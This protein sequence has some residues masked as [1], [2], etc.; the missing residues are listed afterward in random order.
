MSIRTYTQPGAFGPEAIAAMSQAFDAACK[1]VNHTGQP[2]EAVR[3]VLAQRI[4]EAATAGER[5]ADRLRAAA[6]AGLTDDPDLATPST[7]H[8]T[9]PSPP[10][11]WWDIYPA[12]TTGAAIRYGEVE[13]ADERE[14]VEKAAEKFQQP[15]EKLIAVRRPT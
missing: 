2:S 7:D 15:V 1:A 11:F 5:D 9:Q 6:L 13:A 10:L 12:P 3:E 8:S 14:A 4:I